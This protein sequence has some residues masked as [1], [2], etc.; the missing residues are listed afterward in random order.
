MNFISPEWLC[1]LTVK[2]A[3]LYLHS[4]RQNAGTWRIEE[5]TDRQ[6]MPWLL[7]RV[8]HC[9]VKLFCAV[10]CTAILYIIISTH[11]SVLT[12]ELRHVGVDLV[13]AFCIFWVSFFFFVWLRLSFYGLCMK[14][15]YIS[16]EFFLFFERRP[17]RAPH[18][19]QPHFA[20]GREPELKMQV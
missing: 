7:Q 9:T 10:M 6:K 2:T 19:T 3:W 1:Y 16:P 15:H 14:C 20:F 11:W 5:Q 8:M 18:G 4:S 13:L 12:T 17:R